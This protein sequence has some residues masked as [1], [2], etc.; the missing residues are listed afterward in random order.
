[1]ALRLGELLVQAGLLDDASVREILEAQEAT[2]RP[3]GELA[4]QMFGLSSAQIEQA[5][6]TQFAQLTEH[7]DPLEQGPSADVHDVINARQAWQFKLLPIRRDG[8][9]LM[10]ATTVENLPRAARFVGWHMREPVY[11]VLTDPAQLE[12]ALSRHYALPGARL[13]ETTG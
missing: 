11:L 4:E 3:F 13:C 5:W 8:R 1:M 12:E 7:V 10:V 9:E 2:C 6:S